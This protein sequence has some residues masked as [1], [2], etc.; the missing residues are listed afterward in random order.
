VKRVVGTLAG[1]ICDVMPYSDAYE[2]MVDVGKDII[3]GNLNSDTSGTDDES[4][5]DDAP[6]EDMTLKESL[7]SASCDDDVEKGETLKRSYRSVLIGREK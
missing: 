6:K 5:N 2:A 7:E 3:R 1:L 4:R